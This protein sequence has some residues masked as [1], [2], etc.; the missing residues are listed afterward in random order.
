MVN[1]SAFIRYHATRTPDRLAIVY[2]DQHITYA[3]LYDR[4]RRVAALLHSK[5]IS[6][7]DVV[8]VFMKN[9]A[10][11]L[12]LALATS[13]SGA[14]FLPINYR[15]AAAEAAYVLRNA[16]A[17]LLFADAEFAPAMAH[18]AGTAVPDIVT[19]D[20]A[21]QADSRSLANGDMP[22]PPEQAR[23]PQDLFRLMYT[24]GTTDH[25]K[26]VTDGG[27]PRDREDRLDGTGTRACRNHNP[28]RR[29]PDAA[30]AR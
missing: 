5:G 26:G 18:L 14:V 7:D 1:L 3:D 15:L 6:A 28:R 13:Y 27:G 10:A 21:A 22:L 16:E 24:S 30:A 23:Q 25:P 12:E 8:A 2:G 4:L 20:T 29:R 9:S 11:F 19:V 17:R